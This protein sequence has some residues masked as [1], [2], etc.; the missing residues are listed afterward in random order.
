MLSSVGESKNKLTSEVLLWTPIHGH[1]S[2][3]WLTK[4]Y[5][6]QLFADTGNCS[7]DLPIAM[8]GREGW[9]EWYKRTRA[10]E[11]PWWW[12]WWYTY[13]LLPAEC[14]IMSIF[15]GGMPVW[16]HRYPSS[17]VVVQLRQRNSVYLHYLPIS[18]ARIDEFMPFPKAFALREMLTAASRFWTPVACTISCDDNHYAKCNFF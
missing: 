10:V 6:H 2:V 7:E 14:D 13:P 17:R 11:I 18:K 4:I 16:I 1:T 3:D 15:K 8:N 5:I 9:W 12:W